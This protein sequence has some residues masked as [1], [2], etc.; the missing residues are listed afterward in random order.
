MMGSDPDISALTQA[1]ARLLRRATVGLAAVAI[2][3]GALLGVFHE[4][5]NPA[6]WIIVAALASAACY[7]LFIAL[8]RSLTPPQGA[9]GREMAKIQLREARKGLSRMLWL[10][11]VAFFIFGMVGSVE[12]WRLMADAGP[13]SESPYRLFV[14][15]MTFLAPISLVQL[16]FG[17]G[18][19]RWAA[20]I[21]RDELLVAQRHKAM[22][23]GLV[24]L[25]AGVFAAF[26]A[27]LFQPRLGV[28]G[29]P[30]VVMASLAAF[31]LHF[32]LLDKA[33][34]SIDE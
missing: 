25:I 16:L 8:R 6:G 5:M 30:L 17:A 1:R 10:A 31:S 29:L 12:A 11:P 20:P 28:S 4:R 18:Y 2:F 21:Y 9:V 19:A 15:L 14:V 27:G 26:M 22:R 23:T 13:I 3:S 34:G 7:L 24:A 33:A 32:A